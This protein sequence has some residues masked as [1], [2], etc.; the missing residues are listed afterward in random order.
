MSNMKVPRHYR[1][2]LYLFIIHALLLALSFALVKFYPHII[3]KPDMSGLFFML[4]S[5]LG[6]IIAIVILAVSLSRLDRSVRALAINKFILAVL[7]WISSTAIFVLSGYS[8]FLF[9]NPLCILIFAGILY[10]SL[11]FSILNIAEMR[12]KDWLIIGGIL[13]SLV[14]LFF[15]PKI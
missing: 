15:L 3:T 8:E 1:P 13:G 7:Y 5:I 4:I 10:P 14:V 9:N 2:D 11:Y 12:K 6:G